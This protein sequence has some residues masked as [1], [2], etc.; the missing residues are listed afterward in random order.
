MMRIPIRSPADLGAPYGEAVTPAHFCASEK[1]VGDLWVVP[2]DI[3][4]AVNNS[5]VNESRAEFRASVR[6]TL[7]AQGRTR[8][9]LLHRAC[10]GRSTQRRRCSGDMASSAFHSGGLRT[11]QRRL[12]HWRIGMARRLVFGAHEHDKAVLPPSESDCAS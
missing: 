2:D 6:P 7:R 1:S 12:K 11:L 9:Q 4:C 8:P 5:E 10:V 3:Y